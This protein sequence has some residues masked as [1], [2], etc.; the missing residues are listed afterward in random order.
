M[1]SSWSSVRVRELPHAR[2]ARRA[3]RN[4]HHEHPF[5]GSGFIQ[6]FRSRDAWPLLR[7]LTSHTHHTRR[8]SREARLFVVRSTTRHDI[9]EEALIDRC[10]P[11]WEF[12]RRV[13]TRL[14]EQMRR[15]GSKEHAT[16]GPARRP[17]AA[18][19]ARRGESHGSASGPLPAKITKPL[20]PRVVSRDRLLAVLDHVTTEARG[21]F[22]HGPPG[23]GKTTLAIEWVEA[24][25]RPCLW[26]TRATFAPGPS[27]VTFT[28]PR[29]DG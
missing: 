12:L 18:G 19:K 17:G 16:N 15:P 22:I 14:G 6:P 10:T 23:A 1:A 5:R 26:R 3:V 4:L 8:L 9:A 20:L 29:Y 27:S 24:R 11:A 28:H 13:E 21:V 2:P 25:G 7:L